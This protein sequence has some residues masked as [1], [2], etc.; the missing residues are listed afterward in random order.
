MQLLAFNLSYIPPSSYKSL[1]IVDASIDY[2]YVYAAA[3]YVAIASYEA[4]WRNTRNH[5]ESDFVDVIYF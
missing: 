1:A 3:M 4:V 2:M 5:G